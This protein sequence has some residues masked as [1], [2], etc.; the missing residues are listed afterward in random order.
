MTRT[1]LFPLHAVI[2]IARRGSFRAA[3]L[4]LDSSTTALSNAVGKLERELGVRLFNRTTR[5]VSLTDAGRRFVQQVAPA[6]V[7]I[8]EAMTAARSHQEVPTGTLRINS[9]ITAAHEAVL[10]LVLE[11]LARYP[12]VHVD[13]VTEG[14]LIDIVRDGF[15]LGVRGAGSV[16]H[17]MIA[18][19]I[20]RGRRH[21]VAGSP[22]YLAEHGI[23]EVPS[24]LASHRC[25][26]IRL[27][28]GAPYPWHFEKNGKSVK[29]TVGGPITL[30]EASLARRVALEGFGLGYFMDNDVREDVAQGRLVT[31]L[32]DWS[33]QIPPL[34]LYYP[35]RRNPS[36]AFRAFVAMAR[37]WG[38]RAVADPAA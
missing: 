15:D 27:P 18:I 11:F 3:A 17:D 14:R 22:A 8:G 23:P 25:V 32:D 1:G 13:I 36:A 24:A 4:E 16:P 35:N 6:L 33:L 20:R 28:N 2:A 9:F 12:Q 30:D 7:D 38:A 5:S 34:C 19:P 26:A 31:V 21:V 29:V 10:P 37:D